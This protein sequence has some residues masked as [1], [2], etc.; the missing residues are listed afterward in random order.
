MQ[1]GEKGRELQRDRHTVRGEEREINSNRGRE[2]YAVRG[3]MRK[4]TT[5]RGE[6]RERYAV[7]GEKREGQ[8]VCQWKHK[9]VTQKYHKNIITQQDYLAMI[10]HKNV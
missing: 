1:M 4:R 10:L 8:R 3:K 9:I 2:G 5:I 7:R 6:E